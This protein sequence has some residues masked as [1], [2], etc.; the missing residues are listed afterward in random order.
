[1]GGWLSHP[2][3][4]PRRPAPAAAAPADQLMFTVAPLMVSWE[5]AF[6]SMPWLA[7]ILTAACELISTPLPASLSFPLADLTVMSA[8]AL[9]VMVLSLLLI[10][11]VFLAL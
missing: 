5:A 4:P 2:A 1:L 10:T 7:S 11:I 3:S 8:S 9:I 6:R